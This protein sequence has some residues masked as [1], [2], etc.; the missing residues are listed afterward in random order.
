MVADPATGW[1]PAYRIPIPVPSGVVR[2]LGSAA[3]A[4]GPPRG[5]GT[6]GQQWSFH[7]SK[8]YIDAVQF[9]NPGSSPLCDDLLR[10]YRGLLAGGFCAPQHLYSHRVG[11]FLDSLLDMANGVAKRQAAK[12]QPGVGWI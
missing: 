3:G 9:F 6:R 5:R 12:A 4:R 11:T 8:G 2:R 7:D 1:S 10:A